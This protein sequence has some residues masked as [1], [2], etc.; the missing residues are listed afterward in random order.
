[1][2]ASDPD[3]NFQLTSTEMQGR[4]RYLVIHKVTYQPQPLLCYYGA[5]LNLHHKPNTVRGYLSNLL[6]LLNWA[7]E[8]G[9]DLTE[10]LLSGKPFSTHHIQAFCKY[11]TEKRTRRGNLTPAYLNSILLSAQLLSAFYQG[12]H[13]PTSRAE[14]NSLKLL[15]DKEKEIWLLVRQHCSDSFESKIIYPEDLFSIENCL[16]PDN[17]TAN[18]VSMRVA[19]RDFVIWLYLRE[20]GLR[21]GELLSL[22]LSDLAMTPE[23]WLTVPA[24]NHHDPRGRYAPSTKSGS[25]PVGLM[26]DDTQIRK[27]TQLYL[28]DYRVPCQS[29]YFLTSSRSQPLSMSS[30]Q[31]LGATLKRIV[32]PSFN[33]HRIRHTHAVECL[34]IIVEAS[35]TTEEFRS[36]FG[37]LQRRMGWQ[38]PDSAAPYLKAALQM[39]AQKRLRSKRLE[40]R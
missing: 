22:R 32:L 1:M 31:K 39:L 13:S 26:G 30:L 18:G 15:A 19:V 38:H 10:Q 12:L 27:W 35:E 28:E 2:G 17:R 36:L 6:H 29:N 25:R 34:E 24:Q 5:H 4:T 33:L 20:L 37:D 40:L 8:F 16:K 21:V 3:V 9:L 23:C 11:L 7:E 14:T